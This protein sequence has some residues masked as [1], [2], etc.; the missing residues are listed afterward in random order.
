MDLL[1]RPLTFLWFFKFLYWHNIVIQL[2][3]RFYQRRLVKSRRHPYIN[4]W[5]TQRSTLGVESMRK[6]ICILA[7][8]VYLCE[9][10]SLQGQGG[11]WPREDNSFRPSGP[12]TSISKLGH[13]R[14]RYMACRLFGA[15]PCSEPMLA[16]CLRNKVQWNLN[17]IT[18]VAIVANGFENGIC[19]LV[20]ILSGSQCVKGSTWTWNGLLTKF[21]CING[22]CKVT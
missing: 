16:Y 10:S 7:Q 18:T 22:T 17:H 15:K 4:V 2:Y 1:K 14:F 12:Y 9:K 8:C 11:S 19:K 13:H 20:A 6:N 3:A 5:P 21:R